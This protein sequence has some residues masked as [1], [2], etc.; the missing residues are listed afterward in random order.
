[1]T[2]SVGQL[3]ETMVPEHHQS[4]HSAG[5]L[6]PCS[7]LTISAF[8]ENTEMVAVEIYI[9]GNNLGKPCHPPLGNDETLPYSE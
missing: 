2:C 7:Y 8:A 9:V 4:N 6:I 1:M 3:Q 5:T